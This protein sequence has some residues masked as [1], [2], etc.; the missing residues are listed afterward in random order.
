MSHVLTLAHSPDREDAFLYHALTKGLIDARGIEFRQELQDIETLNRCAAE[1]VYDVTSL[2]FHAYAYAADRYVLFSAGAS[3]GDGYGPVVVSRRSLTSVD[4][5]EC[6]VAIPGERTTSYLVFRLF[7]PI[8]RVKVLP[9]KEILRE[10][11][12]GNVDAGLLVS[13][14]DLDGQ[15]RRIVD[16]GEWWRME[17]GLPLPLGGNAIRRSFDRDL[18]HTVGE[19]IQDGM[20]YAL[21]HRKEVLEHLLQH[22]DH[23]PAKKFV[24]IYLNSYSL[25]LSERAAQGLELLYR[26]GYEKG[27]LP[28]RITPEFV[29]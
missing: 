25:E 19:V 14:G 3:V 23:E 22:R 20:Q 16:L 12:K 11:A 15:V 21:D 24:G 28:S 1:G 17:T 26:L 8:A 13:E 2:S 29:D 5:A 4:L 9:Q 7:C 10:V 27:I 18:R 6:M